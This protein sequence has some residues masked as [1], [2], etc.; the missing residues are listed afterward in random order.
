MPTCQHARF[1][2]YSFCWAR[3]QVDLELR[4]QAVSHA[5]AD[6]VEV[7]A[8]NVAQAQVEAQR[9]QGFSKNAR[10]EK[11]KEKKRRMQR[12]A[13]AAEGEDAA[14]DKKSAKKSDATSEAT[15]SARC[16]VLT[17]SMFPGARHNLFPQTH[18]SVSRDKLLYGSHDTPE[19]VP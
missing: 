13:E 6:E 8:D 14:A 10:R 11:K 17:R 5:P 4:S 19:C 9:T 1:R 7:Q 18:T 3:P 15:A 16:D 2:T 12:E